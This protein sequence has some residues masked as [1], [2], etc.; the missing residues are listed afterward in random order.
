MPFVSKKQRRFLKWK[1][2]EL[3][4]KW[5]EKYGSKITPKRKKRKGK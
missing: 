3:Y 4:E 5:E 2:P 1:K